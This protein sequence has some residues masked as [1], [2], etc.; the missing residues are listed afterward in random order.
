MREIKFRGYDKDTGSWHYGNYVRL[1]R[2]SGYAWS[3]DPIAAEIKHQKE[4]FDDYIFFTE[5]ND[6][7]LETKKLKATVV[8]ESVGQ[9]TGLKN[10]NGAEIYE[11]DIIDVNGEIGEVYYDSNNVCFEVNVDIDHNPCIGR[12]EVIGNIYENPEL[13][14][15]K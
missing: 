12:Y 3:G 1:E 4:N 2:V 6:W 7:G 15:S 10:K 5:M 11:G 9:Y 8:R 13:L 14:G